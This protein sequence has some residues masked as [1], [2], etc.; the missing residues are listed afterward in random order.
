MEHKATVLVIDGAGRAAALVYKYLQSPLV[1]N[2]L[3]V[4]GNDLMLETPNVKTFPKLKTTDTDEISAIA[5]REKVDLVDVCQD[6]AVAAGL[7]DTLRKKDFLVLGPTK[8]ASRIE[9]DKAFAR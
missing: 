7:V 1:K 4:P 3:A 2:V 6:D 9:W 5:K 8:K